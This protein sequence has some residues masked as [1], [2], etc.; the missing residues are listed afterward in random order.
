LDCISIHLVALLCNCSTNPALLPQKYHNDF[1]S[2]AE[3]VSATKPASN[4]QHLSLTINGDGIAIVKID[5]QGA[6]VNT[7]GK[8][9][10]AE[11]D[12]ILNTVV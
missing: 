3:T 9:L 1:P 2:V 4:L 10:A 5:V 12:Q 11:F 8:S 7:L 6:K